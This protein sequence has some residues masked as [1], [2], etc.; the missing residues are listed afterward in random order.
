M[1]GGA[2]NATAAFLLWGLFPLYFHAL[3]EVPPVEILAHRMVWSLLFLAIVL[4]VRGQWRW[5]PQV[6]RQPKVIGT[7]VASALLLTANWGIYI[8]AVNNG[9]VLDASLGYFITPLLNVLLGLMVL[10][11]RLR[12]GQ[13]AAIG[14]AAAGVLWLTWVNGAPPWISLALALTFGGYGLLRKTASLGALEGLTL[15]TMLLCPVALLYLF[16]L[17]SHG[18]SGFAHASPGVKL[19]LAAAGPV[20]AVP[21]LLFAA[22]ARRIPLSML[23]LIQYITPTLQ[24]LIGVV[25][26]QEFFGH[27][28]LIG[29]G[30]IWAALAIY[31]LEG[32]YRA[33]A[34]R[35]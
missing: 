16:F 8:W 11:E 15:E 1:N 10:K 14:V 12:P 7:F 30:A 22:G 9:H 17:T 26:Y 25:I 2:L 4:T 23:G 35:V 29:Y 21:L 31:S 27:D 13:W 19:L 32:V 6:A 18:G 33:R 28:Q 24:L 3:G 34:A 20:T 5:L